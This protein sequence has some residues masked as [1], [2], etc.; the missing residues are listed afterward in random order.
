MT[1]FAC[2]VDS[3]GAK[4]CE[5]ARFEVS[6]LPVGEKLNLV[7]LAVIVVHANGD[8]VRPSEALQVHLDLRFAVESGVRSV[9]KDFL[10]LPVFQVVHV[11]VI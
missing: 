10:D 5:W 8:P 3:L 4:L 6:K 7:N 11:A 1:T 2:L 9:P